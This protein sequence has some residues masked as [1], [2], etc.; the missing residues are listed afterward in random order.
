MVRR[1][2]RLAI[3]R[4]LVLVALLLPL[5][6]ALHLDRL[7]ER[8]GA[9][10]EARRR[11]RTPRARRRLANRYYRQAQRLIARK[12]Y[13]QAIRTLNRA[14]ALLPMQRTLLALARCYERSGRLKRARRLY[15]R[16]IGKAVGLSRTM[17]KKRL[18]AVQKRIDA[19]Q[20]AKKPPPTSQPASQPASQPTEGPGEDTSVDVAENIM[21]PG[22][23]VTSEIGGGADEDD[24][25]D[26]SPLEVSGMLSGWFRAALDL[27]M[28]HDRSDGP[29]DILED[30]LELRHRM[31]LR[32]KVTYGAKYQAFV[33]TIVDHVLRERPPDD[34]DT[35]LLFNGRGVRSEF[36]AGIIEAY[37]A[38]SLWRFDLRAGMLRVPWGK[39]DYASP[40][41]IIN[42]RDAR[43]PL[44]EELEILRLP[45]LG[46]ETTINLAP[47]TLEL[48]WQPLFR[49]DR[50]SLYG[51]DFGLAGPKAP[52]PMRGLI[53]FLQG[54][55]DEALTP[56]M[57]QLLL[58]TEPPPTDLRASSVG[59]RAKLQMRGVD[60][61]FYYHYGY[62]SSPYLQMN[63]KVFEELA[64][65]NWAAVQLQDFSPLIQLADSGVPLYSSTYIRRH[66]VGGD[67]V[68]SLGS[69]SLRAEVGVDNRRVFYDQKLEAHIQPALSLN[70]G[71]EY[72]KSLYQTVVI[73]AAY[74]YIGG[75]PDEFMFYN[76]HYAAVSGMAR[77]GVLR[78]DLVGELRFMF[79]IAPWTYVLRPQVSY[80]LT[81]SWWITAGVVVFGGN[82]RSVGGLFDRNDLIFF[83]GTFNL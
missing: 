83:E 59:F 40:N 72:A 30:S 47:V 38:A 54:S 8:L 48:V 11:R 44:R 80:K 57:E 81:Q 24:V 79:G 76:H 13:N 36:D 52:A 45:V 32:L 60:F 71:V 18:A 63:P 75:G 61:S 4:G 78:G 77:W 20:A 2:P 68:A 28:A 9:V 26:A 82:E 33:S 34:G 15:R 27:D 5:E 6:N 37:V 42:P 55:F 17:L 51:S 19:E 39:S 62:D 53:H 25:E 22:G 67:V 3:L 74:L 31:L 35:F 1:G 69:L 65:I 23:D 7:D 66:H 10:A 50:V 43:N 49:G 73:E 12:R 29:T 56:A 46:L 58:V 64:K 14:F 16:I 21:D 70:A 41:D